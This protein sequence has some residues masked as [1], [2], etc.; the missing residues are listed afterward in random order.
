MYQRPW[1]I[2]TNAVRWTCTL[3]SFTLLF[4]VSLSLS[5]SLSLYRAR[6]YSRTQTHT[7]QNC[8]RHVR[9]YPLVEVSAARCAFT[10]AASWFSSWKIILMSF[11]AACARVFLHG[12]CTDHYCCIADDL[13]FSYGL[14]TRYC[15]RCSPIVWLIT[16]LTR[17]A[18][19]DI[20]AQR[21]EYH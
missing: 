13:F 2:M 3:T 17:C 1:L 10:V 18:I 8:R 11:A 19:R 7:R 5:L 12:R 21:S 14:S 9:V 20:I 15:P 6:I 16:G 4:H